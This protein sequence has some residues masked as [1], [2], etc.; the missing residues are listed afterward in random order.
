LNNKYLEKFLRKF[1]F[2]YENNYYFETLVLLSVVGERDIFEKFLTLA[3]VML[4]FPRV[5]PSLISGSNWRFLVAS[6][7][8]SSSGDNRRNFLQKLSHIPDVMSASDIGLNF[9]QFGISCDIVDSL[10]EV[11][12]ANCESDFVQISPQ[13]DSLIVQKIAVLMLL[14][15]LEQ[16]G[17][18]GADVENLLRQFNELGQLDSDKVVIGFE[19]LKRVFAKKLVHDWIDQV[20]NLTTENMESQSPVPDTTAMDT[21]LSICRLLVNEGDDVENS[22]KNGSGIFK[23]LSGTEIACVKRMQYL[24]E[25][26]KISLKSSFP[27]PIRRLF[28]FEKQSVFPSIVHMEEIVGFLTSLALRSRGGSKLV[29]QVSSDL[30]VQSQVY[31][32]IISQLLD[33]CFDKDIEE[34]IHGISSEIFSS[35]IDRVLTERIAVCVRLLAEDTSRLHGIIHTI[36]S[37]EE[38][39]RCLQTPV[40]ISDK[41][42][43][44]WVSV[45]G[46]RD[47]LVSCTRLANHPKISSLK[48]DH[49]GIAR[50]LIRA[51]DEI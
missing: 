46:P 4:R 25:I 23:P 49:E 44:E 28:N 6:V 40:G 42:V 18:V 8:A 19:I 13:E 45:D 32:Q 41:L 47:V 48:F 39:A 35:I 27:C 37:R 34:F 20:A 31:T 33:Q 12:S 43:R 9:G 22:R 7:F 29:F 15:K 51:I 2:E 17:A 16:P 11:Q 3:P 10:A 24:L 21:C 50:R 14:F 1:S 30:A 5:S 38:M 26:L 36:L